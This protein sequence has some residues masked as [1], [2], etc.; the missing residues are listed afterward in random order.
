MNWKEEIAFNERILDGLDLPEPEN[1]E[2]LLDYRDKI[3]DMF[4]DVE[5]PPEMKGDL[6]EFMGMDDLA[7]YLQ[8]RFGIRVVEETRYVIRRVW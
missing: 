8:K 7:V 2:D 4:K 5:L 6:F 3:E 1:R